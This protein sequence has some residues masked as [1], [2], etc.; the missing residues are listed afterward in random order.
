MH[1]R[2]VEQL[3]ETVLGILRV[4]ARQRLGRFV[5]AHLERA[6]GDGDEPHAQ[7]I[8][9]QRRRL[10]RRGRAQ[11]GRQ[12]QTG[13]QQA[14]TD[15]HGG[16]RARG[17]GPRVRHSRAA[18]SRQPDAGNPHT[19]PALQPALRKVNAAGPRR[20]TRPR[21][22]AAGARARSCPSVRGRR[23]GRGRA[24]PARRK[25]WGRRSR[26]RSCPDAATAATPARTG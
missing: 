4:V 7:R 12:Q 16:S 23:T 21:R 26:V 6:G 8:L 9:D 22:H 15:T 25:R 10:A 5:A 20:P 2:F 17:A 13:K 11:R 3:R 1:G 24:C 18:A 19:G 14:G